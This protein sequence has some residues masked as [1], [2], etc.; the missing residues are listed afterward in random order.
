M[1]PPTIQHSSIVSESWLTHI[2]FRQNRKNAK[3]YP[4]LALGPD[5]TVPLTENPPH[6]TRSILG[7]IIMKSKKKSPCSGA[8]NNAF[9]PD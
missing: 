7:R 6:T 5:A 9:E 3:Q 2:F 8:T 4:V 1:A